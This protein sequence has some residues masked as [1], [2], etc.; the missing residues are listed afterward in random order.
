MDTA[1]NLKTYYLQ[2]PDVLVKRYPELKFENHCY[3]RIALDNVVG[4]QWDKRIAKPAYKN[5]SNQQRALAIEYLT[6]YLDDKNM[7][8]SHNMISQAYRGKLE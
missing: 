4:T 2:I 7:L 6:L 3:L 1:I 8:L 5:L